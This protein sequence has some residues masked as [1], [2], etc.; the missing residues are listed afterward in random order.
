MMQPHQQPYDLSWFQQQLP[1]FIHRTHREV[2]R[3][4]GDR[5]WFT[6]KREISLEWVE[7]GGQLHEAFS[8]APQELLTE[9]FAVG[10]ALEKLPRLEGRR[11]PHR[12]ANR[13]TFELQE[14]L[15]V[16]FTRLLARRTPR[17][18]VLLDEPQ[19]AY[20]RRAI[21][22]SADAGFVACALLVLATLRDTTLRPQAQELSDHHPSERIR[23][24][25]SEYLSALAVS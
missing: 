2:R 18:L 11:D 13:M 25:A 10:E 6:E 12:R 24:A 14:A 1:E 8:W 7:Q 19:R 17:E 21:F 23:E 22:R 3:R 16:A 4:R 5:R 9:L 20:L 15:F